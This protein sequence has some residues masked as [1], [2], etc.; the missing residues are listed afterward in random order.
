MLVLIDQSILMPTNP[1]LAQVLNPAAPRLPETSPLPI[2]QLPQPA[3]TPALQVPTRPET[4]P[5]TP[6]ET[7]PET[8]PPSPSS[9]SPHRPSNLPQ[10]IT[11]NRFEFVGNTVFTDTELNKVVENF[12]QRPITFADL[13]QLESLVTK[14]YAE[15]GYITSG[16]VILAGQTVSP[17]DAVIQIK[18]IEGSL[19]AIQ[20]TGNQHL[21]ASY[22]RNR[23]KLATSRVVNQK[24]ILEALQLLQLNPLI[25]T[26]S[27]ELATGSQPGLSLLKVRVQ[28]AQRF[29]FDIFADNGR[30]PSV[31]TLE[32][33][34]RFTQA[35]VSGLGDEL[36]LKYLNTDGSHAGAA[37][38]TLPVNARNGTIKFTAQGLTSRVIEP[39]FDRLDIQ[40]DSRLFEF[41][42][43]QP[44]I[45]KARYDFSQGI[46][47]SYAAS[48]TT[49]QGLRF[50]LA[51]GGDSQGR[52]RVWALR[53]FQDLSQRRARDVLS[54]RSQFS[55]GPG[56]FNSTLND[57]GPDSRFFKWQGQGQYVR[58]IAPQTLFVLNSGL[59]L[60][61][62][63]LVNFEQASLGGLNSVRGY[64][65]DQTLTDNAVFVSAEVR[66]PILQRKRRNVLIYLTP[67]VDYGRGWNVV[68]SLETARLP[69]TLASVGLGLQYQ[70]DKRLTARFD[71]GFPLTDFNNR[72]RNL[73]EQGLYF[74][75]NVSPF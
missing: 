43:R 8:Q 23:L 28:E 49:L 30:V 19:E 53:F 38:Y 2:P 50:P 55:F 58:L 68:N 33:G 32:R 24:K 13:L 22:I 31:G 37:S 17:K 57:N 15:Q 10:T 6:P 41:S 71:W 45:Q 48:S 73:Q 18:I 60:T 66:I 61:G 3:P 36:S 74:S 16:A 35:N 42:F 39:P 69:R 4:P 52:T 46:S 62:N 70:L 7:L 47:L 20:I 51:A 65:Q 40:A 14:F 63:S 27:A 54:L 72:N 26:I 12:T 1:V 34:V 44:L 11:V 21:N 56:I 59:Q 75:I 5:E 67:F 9:V 29:Y 25:K 64:R